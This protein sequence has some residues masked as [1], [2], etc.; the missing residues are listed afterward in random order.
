M[1][2]DLLF[3]LVVYHKNTG[4]VKGLG[5]SLE[6]FQIRVYK[7]QVQVWKLWAQVSGSDDGHIILPLQRFLSKPV[8]PG[9]LSEVCWLL[10]GRIL[11]GHVHLAGGVINGYQQMIRRSQQIN[12]TINEEIK[13]RG[14]E[15]DKLLLPFPC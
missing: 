15:V 5:F 10:I 1:F 3:Y 6:G 2:S 9:E 8:S 11:L 14:S 13:Q 12:T 7:F 4:L